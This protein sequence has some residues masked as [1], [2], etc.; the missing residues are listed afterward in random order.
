MAVS[1][2]SKEF[3]ISSGNTISQNKQNNI[4]PIKNKI[5]QVS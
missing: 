5:S 3:R 1:R 4:I 2:S